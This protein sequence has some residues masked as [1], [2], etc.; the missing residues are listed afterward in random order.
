MSNDLDMPFEEGP[1]ADMEID[2]VVA[3]GLVVMAGT[4]PVPE[5]GV[6]PCL[7]YR[8]A[9]PDGS[10]FYPPMILVVDEDQ[11]TKLAQLV[12]SATAAAIK[13]AS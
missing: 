2:G 9:N 3:S 7:I 11:M 10:G 12:A 1:L 6:M 4:M 13:A 8:F 5:T